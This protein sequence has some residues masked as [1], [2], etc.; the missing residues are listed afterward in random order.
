MTTDFLKTLEFAVFSE[1]DGRD[2]LQ[3]WPPDFVEV[4]S[5]DFQTVWIAKIA[6]IAEVAKIAKAAGLDCQ[7]F[8]D[9]RPRISA[10][11]VCRVCRLR[12]LRLSAD[13]AKNAKNA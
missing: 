7:F 6:V 8:R 5:R 12:L 9:R 4:A 10:K 13:I 11:I 2:C 3:R 1:T